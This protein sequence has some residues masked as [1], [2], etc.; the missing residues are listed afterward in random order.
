MKLEL[1]PVIHIIG[2]WFET[3]PKHFLSPSTK[4]S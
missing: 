4:I 2:I 1:I 3:K